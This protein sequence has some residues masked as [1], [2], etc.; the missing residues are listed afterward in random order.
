MT[1]KTENDPLAEG[2][3]I[4]AEAVK[5]QEEADKQQP[6]PTQEE[7]DR[8]KLGILDEFKSSGEPEAPAK[9]AASYSTRNAKAD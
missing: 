3:R 2:R 4:Q 1:K 5:A 9:A 7:A 6:S 8:A